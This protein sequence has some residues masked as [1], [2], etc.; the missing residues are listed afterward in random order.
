MCESEKRLFKVVL[1]LVTENLATLHTCNTCTLDQLH[2][3]YCKELLVLLTILFLFLQL[4]RPNIIL[5]FGCVRLG[6]INSSLGQFWWDTD[7]I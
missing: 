6:M 3:I 2:L 5:Y 1:I 7:H 4:F